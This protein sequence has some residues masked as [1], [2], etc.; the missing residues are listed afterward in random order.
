MFSY[1]FIEPSL[2]TV[3]PRGE[4]PSVLRAAYTS[5]LNKMKAAGLKSI[6][7]PC[8]STRIYKF[9]NVSACNIALCA[10]REFLESNHENV[11]RVIFCLFLP[12]DVKI[13]KE[14]MNM[15]FPI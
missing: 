6:A 8:I 2:S 7:L 14:R 3:G 5:C 12:K 1:F 15:I 10:V 4:K 13:Y 9:P 11:D